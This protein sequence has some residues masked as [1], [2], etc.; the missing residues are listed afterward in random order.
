MF[1]KFI[2]AGCCWG[3]FFL[4]NSGKPSIHPLAKNKNFLIFFILFYIFWSGLICVQPNKAV[5]WLPGDV[6]FLSPTLF[7]QRS[8]WCL[9]LIITRPKV[10]Q[11]L[12]NPSQMIYSNKRGLWW[13]VKVKEIY[14]FLLQVW[15]CSFS[16]HREVFSQKEKDVALQ[17]IRVHLGS[18]LCGRRLKVSLI[19][20]LSCFF[21]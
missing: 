14:Q 15:R 21:W 6:V 3:C 19:K 12:R 20:T 7:P 8:S 13:N 18:C 10:K 9:D 17:K 11:K 16:P 2:L 5:N 1:F 4:S